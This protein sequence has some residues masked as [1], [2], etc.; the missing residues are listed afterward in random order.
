MTLT[1]KSGLK[2]TGFLKRSGKLKPRNAKRQK[3]NHARAYGS[4]ERIAFVKGL[5]CGACGWIGA[6]EVAH[7]TTGGTGRKADAQFTAPLCGPHP[8][9]AFGLVG[10]VEGCHRMLHRLGVKTFE[11]D[12][13][14][15]LD[16]L[17]ARTEAAWQASRGEG[18]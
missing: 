14:I 7:T 17:A 6:S 5:P 10:T 2:R 15:S 8:I 12:F 4:D 1:R 16:E 13:A 9:S 3:R 11:R 18:R